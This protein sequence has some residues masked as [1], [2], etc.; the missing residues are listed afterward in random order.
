VP[1]TTEPN[2]RI[3][4]LGIPLQVAGSLE[5]IL[6]EWG[7]VLYIPPQ[8]PILRG[9]GL[10][11]D[12]VPDVVFV[13]TGGNP[14]TSLIEVVRGAEPSLPIVAVNAYLKSSEILDALDHGAVDY[15]T[16][17]FDRSHLQ[18]LLQ[19]ADKTACC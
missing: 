2:L 1:S 3:V 19:A 15:C 8:F 5:E 16:P 9:L 13:W 12:A 18:G 11:R 7:A 17:P 14:T 6:S 10:I 4:L